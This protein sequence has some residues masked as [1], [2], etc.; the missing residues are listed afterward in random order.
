MSDHPGKTGSGEFSPTER[1]ALVSLAATTAP[2]GFGPQVS[3]FLHANMVDGNGLPLLKYFEAE[4]YGLN[5]G[6]GTPSLP[7]GMTAPVI[8]GGGR[9]VGACGIS[10]YIVTNPHTTTWAIACQAKF[11]VPTTGQYAFISLAGAAGGIR[12]GTYYDGSVANRTNFA[13]MLDDGAGYTFDT[14][15]PWVDAYRVFILSFDL[16]T[17]R[18]WIGA[19]PDDPADSMVCT[20]AA[21]TANLTHMITD[22]SLI[23]CSGVS[24]YLIDAGQAW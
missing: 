9:A 4:H 7:G 2:G 12:F 20:L 14:V 10:G 21:S 23:Y 8:R 1:A 19:L 6:G 15:V 24:K 16:T 3:R 22:N 5:P 13:F 11:P 17:I 18:L